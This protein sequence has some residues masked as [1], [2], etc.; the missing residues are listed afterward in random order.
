MFSPGRA[1][2]IAAVALVMFAIGCGKGSPDGPNAQGPYP[3]TDVAAPPNGVAQFSVLPVAPAPGLSLTALGNLAPPGHVL[4]TDHVYFYASDLSQPA[5]SPGTTTRPV[6]MPATG[7]LFLKLQGTLDSKLMFRATDNFYFY[8]DHV[9]PT[10]AKSVGDVLQAGTQIGTTDPGGTLDLGAFD[11][12]V[13]HDGF[14]TPERYAFQTLHYVSPWKYFPASMQPALYAQIYRAPSAADK[15]GKIDFG[16]VGALA[17]DWFLQGTPTDSSSQPS[18]WPRTVSFAYDYYDPSLVRI[19]IGGTVDTPGVWTIDSTA[20]RPAAVTVANGV[21][22]YRLLYTGDLSQYG[23]MLVQMVSPSRL[24]I[25]VFAGSKAS[26]GQID[27]RA[28]TFVR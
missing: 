12:T 4:P 11:A 5:H 21:V 1:R 28:S 2:G 7:A 26:T 24:T 25:E 27:S 13:T 16:V 15:D 3:Y 22:A 18:G 8:L 10:I 6:Y 17:G 23:L 14:L 19:S 20:P 9:V